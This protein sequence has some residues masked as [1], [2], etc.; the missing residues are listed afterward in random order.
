MK[1]YYL[2]TQGLY[3]KVQMDVEVSSDED[4]VPKTDAST[5]KKKAPDSYDAGDGGASS[6]KSIASNSIMSDASEQAHP[7]VADRVASI[8]PPASGHGCKCPVTVVR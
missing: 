8:V 2:Q 3:P 5:D 1:V 6:A 4:D 7:F